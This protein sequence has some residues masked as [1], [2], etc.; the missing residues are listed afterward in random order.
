[1][2]PSWPDMRVGE[3]ASFASSAREEANIAAAPTPWAARARSRKSG[4]GAAA[5]SAEQGDPALP[6]H[7]ESFASGAVEFRDQLLDPP[8][9]L[10][11]GGADRRDRLPPGVGQVP[12]DVSHAGHVGALVAAAHR[13]HDVGPFGVLGAEQLRL[14]GGEVDSQLAHHLDD[15]GVDPLAGRRPGRASPVAPGGGALEERLAHLRAAGVVEADEEGVGHRAQLGLRARTI[16]EPACSWT[17][18][19]S[20]I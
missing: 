7:P 19:V 3:D 10:V 20:V 17:R 16:A 14:A 2:Y 15:L 5:Q 12:D 13:H 4:E 9:D 8:R 6:R 1:M 18:W 11:A